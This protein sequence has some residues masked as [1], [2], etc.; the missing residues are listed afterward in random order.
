MGNVLTND[1][2]I[3]VIYAFLFSFFLFPWF[4]RWQ[5]QHHMG[6][7]IKKEGPNLHLH[8]ED[9]PSMGGIIIFITLLLALFL[10][11]QLNQKIILP[12]LLLT[13]FT[14]LGFIDDWYKSFLEK[15]WGLKAR[16]KFL[17]QIIIASLIMWPSLDLVPACIAI[18]FTNHLV[19]LPPVLFFGYGVFII[20]A[21]SNAFNITDGLDGLAAGCGI[22]GFLFWGLILYFTGEKNLSYLSA[23]A[24][25]GLMSFLW[26]NVWPARIFMGDSGSLGL[27]A[28]MGY[29]AIASGQS[30]LLIFS[31]LVFIL[32]TI[33]VILQVISFKVRGRRIFLMSPIH[34]HFELKGMKEPQITIRF[35]IIQAIGIMFAWLGQ[36]GVG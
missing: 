21:T 5:K 13:G 3:Y 20:V 6:Q 31:A 7:K 17:F 10:G 2:L 19:F 23:V 18:P 8:K 30:L 24:I 11:N 12:V 27:G 9:T 26:F 34:H 4:I 29:M 1:F 28:L 32:D 22:L 16:Y 25:G 36:M 14:F 33:S 35:W 15:P